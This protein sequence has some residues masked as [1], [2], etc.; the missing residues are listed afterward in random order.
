VNPSTSAATGPSPS[1]DDTGTATSSLS[2]KPS[3]PDSLSDLI[4]RTLATEAGLAPS[5]TVDP[6]TEIGSSAL[7][8][9]SMAYVFSLIAIEDELGVVFA[10]RLFA[11]V[12]TA[13]V[14][15]VVHYART[16]LT[17]AS[18]DNGGRTDTVI[19]TERPA[20]ELGPTS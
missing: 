3:A 5:A 14:G 15:D 7:P 1:G 16:A 10:D 9:G 6:A 12:R 20:G 13:T 17:A 11:E 19:G 18:P 4:S 8:I 2:A